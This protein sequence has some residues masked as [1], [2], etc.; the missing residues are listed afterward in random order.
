MLRLLEQSTDLFFNCP[1]DVYKK[2][3]NQFHFS[4]S[5]QFMF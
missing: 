4:Q 2:Y 1:L 3:T 5:V